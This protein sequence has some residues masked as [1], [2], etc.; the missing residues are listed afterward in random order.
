[1]GILEKLTSRSDR[2][3]QQQ[4][5]P[6]PPPPPIL[7]DGLGLGTDLAGRP[8]LSGFVAAEIADSVEFADAAS[9]KAPAANVP[10]SEAQKAGYAALEQ[11]AA[12]EVR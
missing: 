1:M 7:R 6:A 11:L 3:A 10:L 4:R 8:L 2:A 5:Y 12:R 9:Y